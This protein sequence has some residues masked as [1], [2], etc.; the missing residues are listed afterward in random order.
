MFLG[1]FAFFRDF[2]GLSLELDSDLAV[3]GFA[4][5]RFLGLADLLEKN[6]SS[7]TVFSPS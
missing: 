4:G 5:L 6:D 7:D 1:T 2:G 3:S